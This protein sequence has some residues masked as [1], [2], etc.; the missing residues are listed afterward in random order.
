[1][2]ADLAKLI[3]PD[4]DTDRVD[5]QQG[6]LITFPAGRAADDLPDAIQALLDGMPRTIAAAPM[7]LLH[8]DKVL[9]W[10]GVKVYEEVSAGECV[11]VPYIRVSDALWDI[12]AVLSWRWGAQKPGHY[13]PGFSPMAEPQFR[14]LKTIDWSC[15][16]QYSAPSMVEVLRS[17]VFYA[18]ARGMVVI[19]TFTSMADGFA[20]VV[21]SLLGK[22]R[23]VLARRAMAAGATSAAGGGDAQILSG[24]AAAAGAGGAAADAAA[25]AAAAA[26]LKR[27]IR[28]EVVGGRE[29]F[30]RAWTLA[31]RMARYGRCEQLCNWMSLEV[32]LGMLV[33]ALLR[34]TD[35]PAASQIYCGLKWLRRQGPSD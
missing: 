31:E 34:S 27:M 1:M 2:E 18:R 25:A 11:D 33:D 21:K 20:R 9:G 32:W 24:G 7:R 17:K 5:D 35:D 14:E 15:A 19:P 3:L 29:Y 16:P 28:R 8:I 30:C 10:S 13:V 6:L 12:T 26:V 22:A 4:E 23:R